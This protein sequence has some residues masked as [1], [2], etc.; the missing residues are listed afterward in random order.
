MP[1]EPKVGASHLLETGRWV[2]NLLQNRPAD[3]GIPNIA[4]VSK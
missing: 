4:V 3:G 1:L 2:A